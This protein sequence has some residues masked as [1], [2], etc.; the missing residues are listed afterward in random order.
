MRPLPWALILV[1]LAPGAFAQTQAV[2]PGVTLTLD[3]KDV[4]LGAGNASR[5]N[6]TLTNTGPA[7]GTVTLAWTLPDGWDVNA[8][9]RT[10]A[11]PSKG[12][13]PIVIRVTAPAAGKG[14]ASADIQITAVLKEDPPAGRSAQASAALSVTRVDPPAPPPAPVVTPERLAMALGALL[15]IAGIAAGLILRR[16]HRLALA[17]AAEEA[18]LA[19]ERAAYLERETGITIEIEGDL[20]PWGLRRELLQR[21]RLKNASGRVRVA[22]VGIRSAPP[23][24]IASVSLPRIPLASGESALVTVY[25]NP[26]A[27]VPGGAETQ[28]VLF[29]KPEEALEREERVTLRFEAPPIR[30]PRGDEAT[31]I[32]LRDGAP[33]PALRR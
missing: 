13:M 19:A 16:R 15:L 21:V 18:R 11:I 26:S 27:D 7:A 30:I 29:A 1:L 22:Q 24:W 5:V 17:R 20:L 10:V 25:L 8:E 32:A 31:T 28:I 6:A 2:Q 12:V 23:G 33:R 4:A 9:T 14:A 3:A